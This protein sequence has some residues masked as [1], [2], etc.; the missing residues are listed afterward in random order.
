[1]ELGGLHTAANPI[2]NMIEEILR[3]VKLVEIDNVWTLVYKDRE[4]IRLLDAKSREDAEQQIV[5]L[6]F[7]RE[8]NE[9]S[10]SKEEDTGPRLVSRPKHP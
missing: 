8:A 4:Y 2:E 1:M 5:E 7:V 6:L 3:N 9:Q 10:S